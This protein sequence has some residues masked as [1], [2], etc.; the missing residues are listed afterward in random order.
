VLA[1]SALATMTVGNL[2]A[3]RQKDLKRLLA[4]SSIAQ[5]GYMLMA[6]SVWSATSVGALVFYL[7]T[8]L[9]MNLAAFLVAGIVIRATGS[10]S[11]S[12]LK[13]LGARNPWLAGAFTAVLLS[14]TGIPPMV[15]FLSKLVLFD[16][17]IRQGF[18]W[19]AVVGLLNGAI[20]LYYYARPMM[21]MY[22]DDV[23]AE[24]STPL[25][26]GAGAAVLT[27]LLVLPV[28]ALFLYWSPLS[29]WARDVVPSLRI[30]S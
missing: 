20:S 9:F 6:L 28:V 26:V 7:V 16:A 25:R 22:L 15:G 2:A 3:C 30:G 12:S 13:G 27:A 18:A 23:T 10:S 24:E 11:L 8:Y 5:A 19:F 21:H 14:L 1:V 4:Y 17:V 29:T